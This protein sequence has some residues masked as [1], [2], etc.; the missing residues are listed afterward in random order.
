[1]ITI[2]MQV[3]SYQNSPRVSYGVKDQSELI[4][5]KEILDQGHI[6]TETFALN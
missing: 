6:W 3:D 5:I 2:S 4:R 1:M